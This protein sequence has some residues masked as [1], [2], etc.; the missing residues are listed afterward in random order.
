MTDAVE[1]QFITPAIMLGGVGTVVECNGQRGYAKRNRASYEKLGADLAQLVGVPVPRVDIGYVKNDGP[2]AISYIHNRS[3]PLIDNDLPPADYSP[4][5]KIALRAACG[6]LPFFAWIGAYDHQ[7]DQNLVVEKWTKGLRVV[8]VDFEHAFGWDFGHEV[9]EPPRTPGLV[10]NLDPLAV[11]R[12]L[13]DIENLSAKQIDDCCG[14]SG[15]RPEVAK[16]IAE[17]LLRR[18]SPLRA[19]VAGRGWLPNAT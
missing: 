6:L 12:I 3:R 4:E 16:S 11:N 14:T 8:A 5:E 13:T 10:A 19:A 7:G 15:F 17:I 9:I 1:W 18:Q 2:F